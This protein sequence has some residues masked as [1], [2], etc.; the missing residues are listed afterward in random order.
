MCLIIIF[1]E[2]R[3]TQ[4]GR[5]TVIIIYHYFA[6]VVCTFIGKPRSTRIYI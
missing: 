3:A 1:A 4:Y 6:V 5:K 2:T